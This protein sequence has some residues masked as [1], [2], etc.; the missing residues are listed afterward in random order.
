MKLQKLAPRFS[1]F[2]MFLLIVLIAVLLAMVVNARRQQPAQAFKAVCFSPDGSR[3]ALG[4]EENTQIIDVSTGSILGTIPIKTSRTGGPDLLCFVNNDQLA[5]FGNRAFDMSADVYIYSVGDGKLDSK[6]QFDVWNFKDSA[7]VGAKGFAHRDTTKNV[8]EFR[9]Y[10]SNNVLAS[11]PVR[12]SDDRMG[13]GPSGDVVT[14]FSGFHQ[15]RM[16]G[17]AGPTPST[18]VLSIDGVVKTFA[19]PHSDAV[20]SPDGSKILLSG[21]RKDTQLL[22]FKSK[23]VLWTCA[24]GI[25][26]EGSKFSPD[27]KRVAIHCKTEALVGQSFQRDQFVVVLDSE[28]GEE[29]LRI[30][31]C[32]RLNSAFA[33]SPDGK[34]LALAQPDEYFRGVEL[35][36]V[37]AGKL[38]TRRGG[39]K[40]VLMLALYP[41]MVLL[42]TVFWIRSAQPVRKGNES[43][44]DLTIPKSKFRRIGYG[45]MAV[46][47]FL[48]VCWFST[49][50]FF[51]MSE[52][53]MFGQLPFWNKS[54]AVVLVTVAC[55]AGVCLLVIGVRRCQK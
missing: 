22:D 35:W 20:L 13:L 38:F 48:I 43:M 27:G 1:I 30:D 49:I 44:A 46:S 29:L 14:L 50:C 16:P 17:M 31:T 28:T 25:D 9:S 4:G 52:S 39:S 11:V 33:F 15:S 41:A 18:D 36:N 54:I 24:E 55:L 6:M 2:Q 40:R 3:L 53:G 5:I 42:W 45:A 47:G 37:D 8:L 34:T 26:S 51:T 32:D 12:K 7:V 21:F 10:E 23:A 19:G